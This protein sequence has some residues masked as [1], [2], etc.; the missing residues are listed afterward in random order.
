MFKFI[1]K[2]FKAVAHVVTKHPFVSAGLGGAGAGLHYAFAPNTVKSKKA[3]II[4]EYRL[5][6]VE[7]KAGL[8]PEKAK[9]DAEARAA[10]DGE[11]STGSDKE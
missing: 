4:H 7:K 6:A 2:G 3:H 1:Q 8:D 11:K 10:A 5:E 9:K